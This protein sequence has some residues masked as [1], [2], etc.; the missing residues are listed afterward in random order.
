MTGRRTVIGFGAA[1]G[2]GTF[3]VVVAVVGWVKRMFE[4]PWV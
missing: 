1:L 4:R 3:V 2:A